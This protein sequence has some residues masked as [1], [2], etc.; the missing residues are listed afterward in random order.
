MGYTINMRDEKHSS[1]TQARKKT[2]RGYNFPDYGQREYEWLMNGSVY[3][4]A[5]AVSGN[6][7]QRLTDEMVELMNQDRRTAQ[8]NVCFWLYE[9]CKAQ[10]F[11]FGIGVFPE[12][13]HV[14]P[15]DITVK[16]Y[17]EQEQKK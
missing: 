16:E 8:M 5:G 11:Q 6:E 17:I 14:F 2:M 9:W 13:A 4:Y 12:N 3:Q 15:H 7:R 1:L 10:I